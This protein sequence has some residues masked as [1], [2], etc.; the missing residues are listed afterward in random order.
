MNRAVTTKNDLPIYLVAIVM[1]ISAGFLDLKVGDLLV[2]ALVVLMCTMLLGIVRPKNP[3][4]WTLTVGVFVPVIRVA[5]Y[6]LF[7]Q[8]PYRAQIY[9][10]ALGFLTGIA[11]AYGGAVVRKG[12]QELFGK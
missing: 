8:T 10:S 7:K 11:G 3:W 9:E 1:G 2:T 4:R 5:A 12:A 6:V